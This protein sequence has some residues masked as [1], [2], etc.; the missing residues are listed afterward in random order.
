MTIIAL[1]PM[2]AH[3]Q[4]VSG[5]NFRDLAGKPLFRWILDTLL[6]VEAI[7]KV[8]I[9]SD[10]HAELEAAGLPATARVEMQARPP[11][12][13]GD[14]VSM[15]LILAHDIAHNPADIYVMTHTTNP[16][17]QRDTIMQ[18][19]EKYRAG[20]EPEQGQGFDSLFTVDEVQMRFYRA[21]GSPVNHDPDNLV[22]TQDLEL[23][24]AENSGLYIFSAKSFAKNKA[25]IGDRPIM[26]PTSKYESV[27]IDTPEDWDFAQMLAQQKRP[28]QKRESQ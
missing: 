18:A 24:L 10:A 7:D 15:N 22:Q 3:S 8:V 4:R 20:I 12:L 27:D 14:E 6:S 25:R 5:K 28:Q 2:K 17:L 23:W 9:N 26:L 1:L 16:F 21:D 19:L 11:E 13:C